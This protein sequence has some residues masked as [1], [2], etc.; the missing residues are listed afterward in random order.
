MMTIIIDDVS[1]N[2]LA[3]WEFSFLAF[4]G[5]VK[6]VLKYEGVFVAALSPTDE[7]SVPRILGLTPICGKV[8]AT[9]IHWI[10]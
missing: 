7:N 6:A 9:K 10:R 1:T 5:P 2:S 3:L 4:Y 8:K